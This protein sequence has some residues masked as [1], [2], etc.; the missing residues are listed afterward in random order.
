MY[1]YTIEYLNIIKINSEVKNTL[2]KKVA[3]KY[4]FNNINKNI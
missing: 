4:W 1:N 3:R 2:K